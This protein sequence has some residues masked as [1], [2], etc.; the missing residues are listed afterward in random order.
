[1]SSYSADMRAVLR[2]DETVYPSI[3]A[4]GK[5][6]RY[7]MINVL[8][9]GLLHA[10]SSLHF[11]A[12]L[13]QEAGP[14][15]PIPGMSKVFF[16]AMG[17]AVAF[18]MHAGA[19]LFLWVFTRGIGGRIAFLPVYF[20]LGVSFI[21]LWPLAPAL[22]AIQGGSG[23]PALYVFLGL[24]SVYAL[25][26]VFFGTKSAS[27]LSMIKMAGAMAVTILF[28]SCFLYLWV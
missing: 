14:I 8:V 21:G 18:F 24:A 15:E 23:N 4:A 26:V 16:V 13:L 2:F 17:V 12:A 28:V 9:F 27:G 1:M 6:V 7:S 20:N 11:S 5:A 10:L 25:G 22:A 19:A 3:M